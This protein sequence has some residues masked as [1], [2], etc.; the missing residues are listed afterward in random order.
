MS[1]IEAAV[2]LVDKPAGPSSFTMVKNVRRLLGIKKVGHAG[3]LDPFASGLLVICAGRPATK[4]ISSL[5]EGEKEYLATLTLGV[6]TTTQDPEGQV[7]ATTAVEPLAEE[8]VERCLTSFVGEQMQIPPVYSAL[9]HKGKPLYYYARKGIEVK[10]EARHVHIRQIER[11]DENGILSGSGA[12]L[13][14]RV[15]CSKG[16]YIRTLA[17]DIGR[18]LGCGAYLS[19][20]RRIRSGSF[21]VT[22]SFSGKDFTAENAY[23]R[24]LAGALSVNDVCNLLQKS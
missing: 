4:I 15:I 11:V 14:I 22:D 16:T 6:E 7:T 19:S 1:D 3:T 21:S 24:F 20:L 18:M 13:T 2:F 10:K 17:A 12:E 23:E 8:V 5:M 9:K